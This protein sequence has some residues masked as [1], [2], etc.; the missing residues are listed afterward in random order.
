MESHDSHAYTSNF[1]AILL[2]S[3]ER[4]MVNRKDIIEKTNSNPYCGLQG[5]PINHAAGY[6]TRK[7]QSPKTAAAVGFKPNLPTGIGRNKRL[8]IVYIILLICIITI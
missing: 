7:Y 4:I 6:E 2:N 5:V 1:F 3:F 8:R